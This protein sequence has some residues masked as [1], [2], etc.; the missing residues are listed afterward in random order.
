MNKSL[1]WHNSEY[2]SIFIASFTELVMFTE[3]VGGAEAEKWRAA[4]QNE[5]D[6]AM[7]NIPSLA[8]MME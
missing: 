8:Y 7:L 2:A 6:I 1:W 4:V 5:Y 3:V